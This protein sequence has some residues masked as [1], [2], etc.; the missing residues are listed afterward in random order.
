MISKHYDGFSSRR[1]QRVIT[2][3]IPYC[4]ISDSNAKTGDV[5]DSPLS[6]VPPHSKPQPNMNSTKTTPDTCD[7]TKGQTICRPSEWQDVARFFLLN[8]G[9][10]VFT[11]FLPP[12]TS[13]GSAIREYLMSLVVPIY[14]IT[15]SFRAI[16][17]FPRR[18]LNQLD[19]AL[20]SGALCMVIP[21]DGQTPGVKCGPN[22]EW[23]VWNAC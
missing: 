21:G 6:I 14:G 23:S 5:S 7:A 22:L 20:M 3:V 18:Q 10:H 11:V 1:I 4:C 19:T 17:N 2:Y 9:L 15:R 16:F 8:Y 13:G 12:G